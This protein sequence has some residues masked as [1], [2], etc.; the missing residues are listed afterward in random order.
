MLVSW[1][2]ESEEDPDVRVDRWLQDN[3]CDAWV[4]G[5]SGADPLDHDLIRRR[6]YAET[7][8]AHLGTQGLSWALSGIDTALWDLTGRILGQPVQRIGHAAHQVG[9]LRL[10]A[11]DG[12]RIVVRS[13]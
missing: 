9:R 3:G 10:R 13:R 12:M 11:V 1:L 6:L 2:A 8:M 5:L 4:L 7:G